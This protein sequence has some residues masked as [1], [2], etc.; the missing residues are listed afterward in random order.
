MATTSVIRRRYWHLIAGLLAIY[1]SILGVVKVFAADIE[2][3]PLPSP[4]VLA[5]HR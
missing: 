1:G 4:C 2:A 5:S 3:A